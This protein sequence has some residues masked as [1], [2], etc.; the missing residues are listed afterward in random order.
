MGATIKLPQ[1][2]L[3]G[4]GCCLK[5]CGRKAQ[6]LKGIRGKNACYLSWRRPHADLIKKARGSRV[7]KTERGKTQKRPLVEGDQQ[8]REKI[9]GI[10]HHSKLSTPRGRKVGAREET[11]LLLRG[12]LSAATHELSEKALGRSHT[13]NGGKKMVKW[14]IE[15]AIS[16]YPP[17]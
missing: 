9:N 2:N 7:E 12:M 13:T 6:N 14:T 15:T 1:L 8:G 11:R 16:S 3:Q 4:S 10:G 5:S 17:G